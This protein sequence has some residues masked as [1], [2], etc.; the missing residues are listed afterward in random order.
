MFSV[1]VIRKNRNDRGEVIPSIEM[2]VHI[3]ESLEVSL[4]ELTDDE[5]QALY[6][7]LNAPMAK[8]RLKDTLFQSHGDR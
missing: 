1:S 3:A 5:K 2:A 7:I 6:S 4:T 8:K